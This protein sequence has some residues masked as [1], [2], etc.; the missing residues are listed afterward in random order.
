M[1]QTHHNRRGEPGQLD[2]GI[3]YTYDAG[4][5]MQ[6]TTLARGNA[7][8]DTENEPGTVSSYEL[9]VRILLACLPRLGISGSR[10]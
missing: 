5:Q 3:G 9:L 6:V 4:S 8:P 10:R 2:D 1:R 7:R